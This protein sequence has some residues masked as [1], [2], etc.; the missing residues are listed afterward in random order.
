VNIPALA[1]AW[2][3][4]LW[5]IVAVLVSRVV[6]I[7]GLG[8]LISRLFD[9]P[10]PVKWQHVLTWGGLRGAISFALVLS[11]PMELGDA[12]NRLLRV[13]TF[14]VV[15][16]TL[17]IQSTTMAKLLQ[18]LRIE[19]KSETQDEYEMR[20]ARVVAMRASAEH[21]QRLHREGLLST[22]AWEILKRET[23][24]QIE[25]L[26]SEMRKMLLAAP[27]LE[28]EEIDNARRELLRAQRSALIGLR[29]DG[30]ISEEAFEQLAAEVDTGLVSTESSEP[31]Y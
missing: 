21:L 14:G 2:A 6:V 12:Q 11:L 24:Q 29:R 8:W 5:S 30:V 17:L 25:T 1:S 28:A 9:E 19:T 31:K 3:P 20:H 23:E 7:Y 4:I 13:M 10:V 27:K 16:F 15:L 22:H 18:W 26:S